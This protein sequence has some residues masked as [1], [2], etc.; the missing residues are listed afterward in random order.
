MRRLADILIFWFKVMF[1]VFLLT[2]TFAFVLLLLAG[3]FGEVTI[4]D[5]VIYALIS[6]VA[7]G[8][9]LGILVALI[10][11]WQTWRVVQKNKKKLARREKAKQP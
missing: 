6:G 9:I 7:N 4:I 3:R 10:M 8:L 1:V 2:S 11:G 5:R